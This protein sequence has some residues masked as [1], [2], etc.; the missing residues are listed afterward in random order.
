MRDRVLQ[1]AAL[2]AASLL[3]GGAALAG[4]W[5]AGVFDAESPR[6]IAETVTTPAANVPSPSAGSLPVQQIYKRSAPAV[7]QVSASTPGGQSQG[8]G[9]VIDK[10]GHV[11]TNFHVIDGAS[12][13]EVSFSNRETLEATLIGSDP[14]TDLAVLDVD[15]GAGALTPLVLANSDLVQVGDPVVAIGNPFGL[16]R[17][18]TAGIVS[19]LQRAVTAPNGFQ[20]DQAIQTDAPINQG[21]SGG[22]LIDAK[23]HVIGVNSQIETGG[24]AR[25]NVGIGFAVPSN[26]VKNVVAQILDTGKVEHAFLGISAVPLDADTAGAAGLTARRGLLV[27]TVSA[28]SGAAKAGIQAG[29][30][31][32]V[33]AGESFFVGGDVILAAA[34]RPVATVS[35]LRAIV[36]ARKPGQ[37]IRLRILR[38]GAERTVTATLGKQPTRPS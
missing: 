18:V 1:F 5:G 27:Q 34:G 31:Q 4:A 36:S 22:P 37:T 28:G 25:G 9:F 19:A 12:S 7:V 24:I 14:S 11:V 23:G 20:I 35:D 16:E 38:D 2:A 29:D 15:A 32:R 3:G 17:T 26:T 33:I 8:S 21:N 6:T 13:I 10:A 30:E